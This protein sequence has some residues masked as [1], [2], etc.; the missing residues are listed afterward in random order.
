MFLLAKLQEEQ[1]LI[2]AIPAADAAALPEPQPQLQ[3]QAQP[4][5]Q[6]AIAQA[7]EA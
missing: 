4:E 7:P 1:P 5:A 6:P 2:K 3:L